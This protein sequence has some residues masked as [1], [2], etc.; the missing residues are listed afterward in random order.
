MSDWL[1]DLRHAMRLITRAPGFSAVAILVLSTGIGASTLMFGLVQ[2]VLL[3]TLPFDDPARVVWMYN[4]RTE[5]D[6][7]PLS[8]PDVDDYRAHATA[9]S[10][11]ATFTNWTA[12][13]TG[14]GTPERLEGTRVSGN[15]FQLLGLRPLVGRPLQVEDEERQARVAVLTHG[16]WTRRFGADASL[17]GRTISLNGAAYTVVGVLPPGF[18]FPFR[19]A[20]V[21][22]PL[23]LASD[24]RRSDRGANFLRVIA[25]LAPGRSLAQAKA[26]LDG[27]AHRLQQQYPVDNARKIGVS[28]Y[29]L[30]AEIVRDYSAILWTL[31]ASVGVLLA[32]GCGNLANLL[33][34]RNVGRRGEFATRLSIGATR[35]R[36]VRQLVSEATVL[37]SAA[38][39]CGI[40][41]ATLGLFAWR[42]WGPV[43]F[44]RLTEVRIDTAVV[45]FAISVSSVAAVVC[46]AL[47]AWFVSSDLSTALRGLT[48]AATAARGHAVVRRLFVGLQI[49]AATVLLV[50]MGIAVRSFSRLERVGPGFSPDQS[51]SMQLSL[52]PATYGT[53]DSLVAF[54]E[55]LHD[56]LGDIAGVER[57]G[58]VS[59]LPLSGLLSTMDIAFPDRPAPPPDEVPQAHF[60]VATPGYFGAAGI[61]VVEGREFLDHDG[62]NDRLVAVISQT[63]AR[64]HWPGEPAVGK[65][66]RL[67]DVSPPTTIAV[68]GVVGD[69]KHFTMDASPT[70]DLYVPLR[71]MPASQSAALAARMFW[72]VRGQFD[73]P[74]QVD[75]VRRAIAQVDPAVATSSARTL[76]AVR[77]NSLGPYRMNVRVLEI[78]GEVAIV[79]CSLG[80]Y[81]VAAFSGR[82][83]RR[84]LA[85]RAAL[86]ARRQDLALL[87]L[88]S[89]LW[90][91]VGGT[92]AG[93]LTAFIT[94]RR[95]FG[96]TFETSPH[97]ATTYVAV[98]AGLSLITLIATYAPAR[99]ASAANPVDALRA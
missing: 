83:R 38:G 73:G 39:I 97:D 64:R 80:V 52:P 18:M 16:L 19:E 62:S 30:H 57:S 22:V 55:R 34:V 68:V 71:Q 26:E 78:F 61:P 98:A 25:R 36:L 32:V 65:T 76:A 12:N 86:G 75:A 13:L 54:S 60:R 6:R 99:R 66:V 91:V 74:G 48:R 27:I 53:R 1:L 47:P 84:E 44:P 92:C 8:I 40:G 82:T 3:R 50:A 89:E 81:A 5:R 77:D 96:A 15:F 11:L 45:L 72:I 94:G 31:F 67:V 46:G 93:L 23:T 20:E 37:A 43:S 90:P 7:A 79:L 49:A 17:V 41:L 14:T 58:M 42:A 63:F 69:V 70:A 2:A 85:I 51:L 33:L 24:P 56:R 59:L 4:L 29:P 21:A 87:L 95:L 88:R 35:G 10:G 9:I 28:L